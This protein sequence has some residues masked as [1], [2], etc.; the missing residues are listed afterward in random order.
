[1]TILHGHNSEADA[2][3]ATFDVIRLGDVD[4]Y[5]N[6]GFAGQGHLVAAL[7][8]FLILA[9]TAVPEKPDE[10]PDI[11]YLYDEDAGVV[12]EYMPS[13]DV[14]DPVRPDFLYSTNNGPR[15]VEFYAPWCP[16]CQS[17]RHHFVEVTGQMVDAAHSVGVDLKVYAISCQVHKTLCRNWEFEV[18]PRLRLFKAGETNS[19]GTTVYY[20]FYANSVLKHLKIP[21][22]IDVNEEKKKKLKIQARSA[23][24]GTF[25]QRKQEEAFNDALVSFHF[26]LRNS[27]YMADGPLPIKARV[28]F[29]NWLNLLHRAIP[30]NTSL[31]SVVS[32]LL[33]DF[34]SVVEDEA[35]LMDIVYRFAPD[36]M[37][38]SK[39][40]TQGTRGAGYTCGLW[41]LFHI[42][43]VGVTEW[44]QLSLIDPIMA[45]GVEEAA[46]TIRDYIEHFFGCEV[47]RMNFMAAFD[48]CAHD[49]CHR[50]D[51]NAASVEKWRELPLWLFETHN[52]VNL[53]LLHEKGE[54]EEF[55]PTLQDEINKQWPARDDCPQCWRDDGGWVEDHVIERLKIDYW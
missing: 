30:P 39:G 21:V 23:T 40:C 16:F 43:T 19:T 46:V 53:R 55:T 50:L 17:F 15:I 37:K 28:A 31:H 18:F 38:W 52:S 4:H 9:P 47:C 2:K 12:I 51:N 25:K 20:Q 10:N 32:A 1:M 5:Y 22:V 29:E 6:M 7:F 44:N 34:E 42:A 14:E 48:S 8:L 45:I 49:R 27:I 41:E 24:T 33:H 11:P 36:K 3:R 26:A 13:A 35:A 54:R